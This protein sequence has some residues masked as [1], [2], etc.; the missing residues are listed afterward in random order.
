MIDVY[1]S[2]AASATVAIVVTRYVA[3]GI[4]VEVSPIMYNNLGSR[5]TLILLGSLSTALGLLPFIIWR[6]G[7]WIRSK[8]RLSLSAYV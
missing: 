6:Y 4:M 1:E 8:S 7:P 3:S 5:D 2:V